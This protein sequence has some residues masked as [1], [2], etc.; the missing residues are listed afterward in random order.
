MQRVNLPKQ[1]GR[2]QIKIEGVSIGHWDQIHAAVYAASKKDLKAK[3]I[4]RGYT[5]QTIEGEPIK[6]N[7][8]GMTEKGGNPLS[9]EKQQQLMQNRVDQ[10]AKKQQQAEYSIITADPRND[11]QIPRATDRGLFQYEYHSDTSQLSEEEEESLSLDLSIKRVQQ[12]APRQ[13]RVD[14][15]AVQ[16]GTA[17]RQLKPQ[18]DQRQAAAPAASDAQRGIPKRPLTK[19][20]VKQPESE[21][22]QPGRTPA[23]RF[24]K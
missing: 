7:P 10:L 6:M 22:K 16:A 19:P 3:W 2:Y 5:I 18:A 1:E 17:A 4:G 24:P 21:R 8:R 11:P 9:Q 14:K 12:E 13:P 23:T 15:Q 20:G